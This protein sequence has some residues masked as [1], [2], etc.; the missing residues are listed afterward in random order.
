MNRS[1]STVPTTQRYRRDVTAFGVL[2]DIEYLAFLPHHAARFRILAQESGIA[3]GI[4]VV[5][6]VDRRQVVALGIRGSRK[7]AEIGGHRLCIEDLDWTI[8]ALALHEVP[9]VVERHRANFIVP[10]I[11]PA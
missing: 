11:P 3:P 2:S 7:L 10:R 6:V 9:H 1:P 8:V 4:K 5:G